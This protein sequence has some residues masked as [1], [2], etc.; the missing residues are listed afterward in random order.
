MRK[1]KRISVY[2]LLFNML[3]RDLFIYNYTCSSTHVVLYMYSSIIYSW[4]S[5]FSEAKASENQDNYE[6][7]FL[8]IKDN[9]VCITLKCHINV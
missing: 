9:K 1:W 5:W 4:F 8:V 2:L 3:Y 6:Y 7:I